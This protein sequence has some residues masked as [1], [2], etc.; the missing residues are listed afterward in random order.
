MKAHILTIGDEI[1]IGQIIDTN[2]AWMGEY[3]SL[4]GVEVTGMS[5]T[6]DTKDSIVESLEQALKR[7]DVVLM[8]GGLGPTKDD[9][10]KKT[11][12]DYFQQELLYHEKTFQN[13]KRILEKFGRSPN[14]SHKAQCYLPEGAIILNNKMGTA[15]GMWFEKNGKVIISMPGVPYEMKYL[16]KQEVVPKL[17]NKFET[18][19][20]LFKTIQTAGEGESRIAEK[21]SSYLE[22]V[23]KNF[24]MAYLPS[25][26]KVRLRLGVKGDDLVK[27]KKDL[28]H[29]VSKLV[30][31]LPNL[32]FGYDKDTL[33]STLGEKLKASKLTLSCAESCTGGFVSHKI[34]S[35]PGSSAYFKGSIIA[36]SN[37]V[38]N[39]DLNVNKET[40]DKFGAVSE[41]TVQEM[42]L[43][44]LRAFDTDLG[45]SISGIA[46]PSGGTASKPVGTIWIAI[47][48]NE[49]IE[50]F[51]LNL[52]KDRLKNIEYTANFAL[53]K[54][55][56][57]I[58]SNYSQEV[59]A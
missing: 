13:L 56:L 23:P 22:G 42:V 54:L 50:T 51:K 33:A 47:G 10:T 17:L 6:S 16:V 29:H 26:G 36:Y 5:T 59:V 3:L 38:K 45:V 55:R 37:D 46:G 2:A 15:P 34:T 18:S 44:A 30:D 8:S 27:M 53:N 28:D 58:L 41:E 9:V 25:L 43:G 12:A 39:A 20:F 40:L 14:D 31:L 4:N 24:S 57:F 35:V 11:L 52:G 19:P 32:V 21:I 7:V 1:L 48:N 49:N